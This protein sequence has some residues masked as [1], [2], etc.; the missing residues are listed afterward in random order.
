MLQAELCRCDHVRAVHRHYRKGTDCAVCA[1]GRWSRE[2]LARWRSWR[3]Y[4]RILVASIDDILDQ[5]YSVGAK[6]QWLRA[7]AREAARRAARRGP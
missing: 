2:Y 1:C 6:E 4:R 5:G 7:E 3:R